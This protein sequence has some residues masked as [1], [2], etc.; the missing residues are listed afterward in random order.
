[1]TE[2]PS[3]SSPLCDE[4]VALDVTSSKRLYDGRVWDV[5]QDEVRYGD[6]FITRDYVRHSGA[7]AV[8]AMDE[9]DRVVVIK[10]YRH[11]VRLREWEIPAG[12]LDI[13]GEDPLVCA[14][15][16]LAEEVDLE[17]AT[18]NLLADYATSPGGSDEI[19]RVYLARDL[20]PTA[21]PHEREAEESDMEL[22]WVTLEDALQAVT[23]GT[24]GNSIFS[25][26]MLS[27][28]YARA[29]GWSTLRAADSPWPQR[30]WRDER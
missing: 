19:I 15:R 23:S 22:R 30:D 26:A 17:A 7:V 13:A 14:K 24:V 6:S 11:P 16:E 3:D 29:R 8:L 25:I 9:Q 20:R 21:T 1:M 4:P 5:F 28:E 18:W 10:Q 2:S 27:A 12:L